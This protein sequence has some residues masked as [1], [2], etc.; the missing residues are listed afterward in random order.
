MLAY[1]DFFFV[2]F[3]AAACALFWLCP[4]PS[5]NLFIL[6]IS[7]VFYAGWSLQAAVLLAIISTLTF[8]AA[9]AIAS[10]S[11]RNIGGWI[12]PVTVTLLALW[13]ISF[14]A[15]LLR[16]D[17]TLVGIAM[18]LGI[19]YY[20]F[21]LISYVLEVHWGNLKPTRN[22]IEFSGYVAFFPQI[23]AGPIQRPDDYLRQAPP[24]SIRIR[25]AVPRIA[26]GFVK[27]LLI[28][29]NLGPAVA[30][31]YSH[32]TTLHGAPLLLGFYL[33]PLQLYADFSGLT[34][35]AIGT[36]LLFGIEGPENFNRPFSATSISDYWRRWHMSLTTWLSDYVFTPLRMATRTSGR[37]GLAFSIFVN[38]VAIGLWHGIGMTFLIFG[39]LHSTFLITD[40]LTG[41]AR[42]RFFKRH[43]E[44]DTAGSWLGWLLTFHVVAAAMVFFRASSV[45]DAAWLLGH[46][47][48]GLASSQTLLYQTVEWAGPRTLLIGLIGYAL[49]EIC[50]RTRPDRWLVSLFEGPRW[51]RWSAWGGTTVLLTFGALLL[52]ATSGDQQSPFI[53][54]V[55]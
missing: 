48:S 53:Y 42:A 7:Y 27:K 14:K 39:L 24:V 25:R 16:P 35:I 51:L 26:W 54:A 20:T 32:V 33:F 23:M 34:D 12:G 15:A 37:A 10:A 30:Y 47:F 8:L 41:K 2:C 21:K 50:E 45:S 43:R 6:I 36:G 11:S 22:L 4:R 9:L 31:V 46:L 17:H 29:D 13:L 40:A 52:L 28:A 5:R 49:L 1:T 55:F 3:I 44:W 38:M 19:S 18:P